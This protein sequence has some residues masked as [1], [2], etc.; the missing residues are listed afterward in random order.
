MSSPTGEYVP[1][2]IRNDDLPLNEKA[3][4]KLNGIMQKL[5]PSNFDALVEQA[6]SIK[7][8][9]DEAFP[10]TNESTEMMKPIVDVIIKNIKIC[11]ETDVQNDIYAKMFCDLSRSWNGN[12]G[13]IFTSLVN[14]ELWFIL[15]EYSA[16]KE[17][18][19]EYKLQIYSVVAFIARLYKHD[20]VS[21]LFVIRVLELFCKNEDNTIPVFAKLLLNTFDKLSKE[22]WFK[23]KLVNKYHKLIE[24]Y[25]AENNS[26][27]IRF[28]MVQL[29]EK[30]W[31][32]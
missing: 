21:G 23:G 8:F 32:N 5:S 3:G 11:N 17:I 29:L 12:Q 25:V 10:V 31:P 15:N 4:R 1:R 24:D 9:A 18:S 28:L 16:A 2:F 13:T 26:G 6:R 30:K 7:V 19:P 22:A 27:I 14:N 20:G